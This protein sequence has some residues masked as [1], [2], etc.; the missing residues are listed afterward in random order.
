MVKR[1]FGLAHL[2]FVLIKLIISKLVVIVVII[3]QKKYK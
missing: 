1:R 2:M 3:G